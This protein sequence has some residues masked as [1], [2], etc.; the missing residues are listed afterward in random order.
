MLTGSRATGSLAAGLGLKIEDG[1]ST[2]R[3]RKVATCEALR[4]LGVLDAATLERLAEFASPPIRDPRGA[5]SGEVRPA[6]EL[7]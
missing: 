2:N 7:V 5:S 3:A 4:Q 1:D 6:F